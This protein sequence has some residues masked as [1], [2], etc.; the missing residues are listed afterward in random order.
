[1]DVT[2]TCANPRRYREAPMHSPVSTN[3]LNVTDAA[4]R[5]GVSA[6]WLNKLRVH[7]GGPPYL[8]L[9][10]RVS[11]RDDDLVA[12]AIA[13]RQISTSDTRHE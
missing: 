5:L 10:R 6:S 9:G 4:A 8:K 1:M 11:Y 12:W 2:F 7:G 13:Q 3:F